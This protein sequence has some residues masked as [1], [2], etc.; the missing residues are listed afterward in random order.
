[1][2]FSTPLHSEDEESEAW[3]WFFEVDFLAFFLKGD[4]LFFEGDSFVP[5][6][7]EGGAFFLGDTTGGRVLRFFDGG[8]FEFGLGFFE[9]VPG[10]L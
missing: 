8:C 1:M 6:F 7:F 4:S 5:F 10:S 9:V 2:C 3:T